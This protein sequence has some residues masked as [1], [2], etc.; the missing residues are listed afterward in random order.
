MNTDDAPSLELPNFVNMTQV[1][2]EKSS[3]RERNI[4]TR[5]FVGSSILPFN[6]AAYT[7]VWRHQ[8]WFA[9]LNLLL[10]TYSIVA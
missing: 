10:Y 9:N 4:S 3:A 7:Q 6:I 8:L 2:C 1:M 5:F